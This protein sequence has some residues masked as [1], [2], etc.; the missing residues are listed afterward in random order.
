MPSP[1]DNLCGPGKP[2]TRP[3][4]RP[5]ETVRGERRTGPVRASLPRRT[6]SKE[7][8]QL[9][10][11]EVRLYLRCNGADGTNSGYE[12]LFRTPEFLR[13][14]TDLVVFAHV[15]ATGQEP[16]AMWGA[17]SSP[18]W[19]HSATTWSQWSGTS[20]AQ[21]GACHLE[22][23]CALR[24]TRMPELCAGDHALHPK[25]VAMGP[26]QLPRL[27]VFLGPRRDRS[28]D[29]RTCRRQPPQWPRLRAPRQRHCV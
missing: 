8:P 19:R 13:P 21:A 9:F 7:L 25:G 16:P 23:P 24:T 29:R 15:D 2:Q 26:P 5:G 4:M 10:P 6:R 18:G 1:L 17:P 27:G 22:S 20:K 11:L 3:T 28:P 12:M 14:V